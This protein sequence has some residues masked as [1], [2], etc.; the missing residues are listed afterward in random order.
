MKGFFLGERILEKVS[1]VSKSGILMRPDE[2]DEYEVKTNKINVLK[3]GKDVEGIEE[4]DT[5]I[6]GM[7]SRLVTVKYEGEEYC[8]GSVNQVFATVDK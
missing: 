6:V 1:N 3:V 5:V 8:L 7:E 2:G 4:G